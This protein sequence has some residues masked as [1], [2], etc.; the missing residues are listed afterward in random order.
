[1]QDIDNYFYKIE[2]KSNLVLNNIYI[3]SRKKREKVKFSKLKKFEVGDILEFVYFYK[4]IPLIF[5]GICLCIK[6]KNFIVPNVILVIRNVILKVA[7]E[8]IV[9]YFYNRVYTLK[10]LDFKRKFF[11]F[12]KNKLYF[13][14][15]RVNRE[16]KIS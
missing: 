3:N 16:S 14:R 15:K 6:R 12:N 9:S 10:F 1:M 11:T 13:I 5:S 8:L 4:N 2:K 7:I